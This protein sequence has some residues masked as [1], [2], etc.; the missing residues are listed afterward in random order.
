MLQLQTTDVQLLGW[1]RLV[2]DFLQVPA[3]YQKMR[4]L[5][6]YMMWKEERGKLNI[7]V[8][9]ILAPEISHNNKQQIQNRDSS[10]TQTVSKSWVSQVYLTPLQQNTDN[11]K[12]TYIIYHFRMVKFIPLTSHLCNHLLTSN[13]SMGRREKQNNL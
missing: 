13:C 6:V 9:S 10:Y 7:F 1:L 2:A 11:K 3:T 5:T 12:L 4:E 8:V